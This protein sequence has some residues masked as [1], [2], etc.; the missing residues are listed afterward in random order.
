VMAGRVVPMFTNNGVPGA[1]A[2]RH[3]WVEK[4]SLGLVLALAV[5]DAAGLP[6][7]LVATVASAAAIAHGVRWGLW[8]PWTTRKV[9]LVWVLHL[10]YLWVP[11]HL[12]LRAAGEWGLVAPSLAI[13]ALTVGAIGGL[14]IGMM[15]RTAR[16]HTA[17]PLRADRFDTVSYAL[18]LSAGVVR[19]LLP[20]VTPTLSMAAVIGSALL[21]S[22]G[23]GLYTCRYWT[24]LTRPRLDGKPG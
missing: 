23:F 11:V 21:W 1:S 8:Q 4:A 6:G 20:L 9:P 14:I 2:G 17:R 10:A 15:T 3:P 19:V 12:V 22:A 7:A 5:A 24:V 16:G 18:V 13:H